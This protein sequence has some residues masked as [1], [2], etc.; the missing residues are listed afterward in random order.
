[1][2]DDRN[3]E[4]GADVLLQSDHT[5]SKP[6]YSGGLALYHPPSTGVPP[7]LTDC[8]TG[9]FPCL[10]AGFENNSGPVLNWERFLHDP[11]TNGAA[12]GP[13]LETPLPAPL[14]TFGPCPKCQTLI[15]LAFIDPHSPDHEMRTYRC[16]ECGH[17][18][19]K[20]V[21]YR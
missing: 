10:V 2:A 3:D 15:R 9:R 8:G 12:T 21:K 6:T 17:S 20:L 7:L 4:F 18:E 1:M 16:D 5:E 14:T 19:A 13:M 11:D